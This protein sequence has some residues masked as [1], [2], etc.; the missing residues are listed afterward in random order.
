MPDLLHPTWDQ[1]RRI[2]RARWQQGEHIFTN[3]QTGSGK[4]ELLSR[5]LADPWS[6]NRKK[7]ST[8]FVTKPRD[9]LFKSPY[10]D[11][12][13]RQQAFYPQAHTSKVML[14]APRGDSTRQDVGNQHAIFRDA[15]DT[16]YAQGGWTVGIDETYWMNRELA[17]GNDISRIAYMG[18]ALGVTGIFNTQRPSH[19]PVLIPQ[20]ATHAFL[21][22][23][24]RRE[25]VNRV[26]ELGGDYHETLA[27]VN[28]LRSKH[29]FVYLDTQGDLPLMIVNTHA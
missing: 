7:Y 14:S 12:F 28:S 16:I 18:R 2:F 17:L 3:G 8:L 27:A 11:G 24:G 20:S 25:D 23:M 19:I 13:E 9:P 29:D 15:L 26:A 5:L 4:S 10:V 22:K 21:G 6:R 1:F